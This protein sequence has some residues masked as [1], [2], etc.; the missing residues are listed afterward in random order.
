MTAEILSI[1][2][3]LLLGEVLDTNTQFL[4]SE[5]VKLGIDCYSHATV[6]DNK[7]RIKK[8]ITLALN[9]ADI[10][11]TT[12]GL[13]PTADDLTIESIAELFGVELILDSNVLYGIKQMFAQRHYKMSESNRK[14]AYRP[15]GASLL[16]NPVGTAPGIIWQL[17]EELLQKANIPVSG[18]KKSIITFP[19]VPFECKAMWSE[20]AIPFL[21]EHYA[22]ASL[23]SCELKHYGIGESALAEKYAHLLEQSNPTVAPYAGRG[24]CRLR[25]CAKASSFEEAKNLASPVVEEIKTKSGYLCYGF[26]ND[27]LESVVGGLLQTKKLT[28]AVA[29]SCTGGLISK[30]LTDISGSSKYIMSNIVTYSDQ[31]KRQLLGVEENTLTRHGAVSAECAQEMAQGVRKL[32]S[33]DIGLSITGIAGPDGGT[34]EKPVGLVYLG[35][36]ANNFYFGKKLML[37]SSAPRA[38]IRYRSANDALNMVRLYLLDPGLLKT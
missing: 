11:I 9:R 16:P 35:L 27:T 33:T 15:K 32:S 14:Q 24:E 5:L 28:I 3:E 4:T 26:D 2:T 12:G 22:S 13:G 8:A 37:G 21:Q 31:S 7:E 25:V 36:A 23:W 38:E 20:T 34:V 6:G 17:S 19:G 10:V 18:S 30:R 1:G 29:E